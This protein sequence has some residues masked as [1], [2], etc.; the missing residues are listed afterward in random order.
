MFPTEA[1]GEKGFY[2]LLSLPHSSEV[3]YFPSDLN[4]ATALSSDASPFDNM[5]RT[6]HAAQNHDGMIVQVTE[7]SINLVTLSQRFVK[8]QQLRFAVTSH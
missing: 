8:S 3:L 6:L 1:Q 5:S 7:T 2:S 4:N